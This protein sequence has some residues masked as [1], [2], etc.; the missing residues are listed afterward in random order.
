MRTPLIFGPMVWMKALTSPASMSNVAF[1]GSK[2]LHVGSK[3]YSGFLGSA[4]QDDPL[5]LALNSV[6][7]PSSF[8]GAWPLPAHPSVHSSGMGTT[9][10]WAD[11]P[12]TAA[13]D[14]MYSYTVYGTAVRVEK[15]AYGV[16]L[17]GIRI[18]WSCLN[19]IV[20]VNVSNAHFLYVG[21]S[22]SFR[23]RQHPLISSPC[24]PFPSVCLTANTSSYV[25]YFDDIAGPAV[26]LPSEL[27]PEA[28]ASVSLR[29]ISVEGSNFQLLHASSIRGTVVLANVPASDSRPDALNVSSILIENVVGEV[30]LQDTTLPNRS[31][32]CFEAAIG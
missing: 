25:F 20:D 2:P 32:G 9:G 18:S 8:L 12:D 24:P 31:C 17:D 30:V 29:D 3:E 28:G 13:T 11:T 19:W 14:D 21:R 26:G 7:A 15:S 4:N 16:M 23:S 6:P 27:V 10:S 22:L 5:G 1:I